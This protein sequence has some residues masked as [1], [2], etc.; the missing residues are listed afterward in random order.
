MDEMIPFSGKVGLQ[1]RVLPGYR[2][3]FFDHL[4][5]FCKG[6][7]SVFAGEPLGIESIQSAGKLSVAQRATARNIHVLRGKVYLC[8]QRGLVEWLEHWDPDVLI[9][10]ANPRYLSNRSAIRWM[11][12]RSRPV[13]GW[14]LGG[15]HSKGPLAG[16]GNRLRT[17][18]LSSFDGLIAY[19]RRGAEGYADAGVLPERI[20]I[21]INSATPPP[22]SMQ[23]RESFK[24]RAARILFVG[25]LQA[26]KRV[27]LL[28]RACSLVGKG[29]ECWIVGDGPERSRL[30]KLAQ[31]VCPEVR[32]LGSKHGRE[33]E[34]LFNQADLFVLPG[35]GGLAVQEA[36]AH[37]LPVIVAEGDGTQRDLVGEGN[38]W[39]VKPGDLNDLSE[40]I[41]EALEDPEELLKKGSASYQIVLHR[42]N[43]D[44]MAKVF[45]EVMKH[46]AEGSF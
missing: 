26:R 19:S 10:E 4:A 9:L 33:L 12:K 27:D 16:I 17:Q 46:L 44:A 1:Q 14:G 2:A 13:V 45:L 15:T 34:D 39:L 36:M 43:I 40:A 31:D 38:G 11:R 25:R 32:F 21:A 6:G 22:A 23:Q 5:S 37:G 30:E 20:H 35:T 8:F 3:R 24:E 18:Y 41:G 28:L 42:A 29:A 7:L